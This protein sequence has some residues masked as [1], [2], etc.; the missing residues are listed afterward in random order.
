MIIMTMMIMRKLLLKENL[1]RAITY[2]DLHIEKL[3]FILKKLSQSGSEKNTCVSTIALITYM[4]DKFL[5]PKQG[6]V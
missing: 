6:E 4:R 3:K 2:C 1:V 5:F